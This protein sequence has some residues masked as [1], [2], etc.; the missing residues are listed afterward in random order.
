MVATRP[1]RLLAVLS[2]ERLAGAL[3]H[4]LAEVPAPL[5][6]P[7]HGAAKESNLPSAGFRALP[8]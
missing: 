8:V 7:L 1:E 3:R 4:I 6:F 5:A 2:R